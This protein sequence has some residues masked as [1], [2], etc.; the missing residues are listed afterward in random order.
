MSHNLTPSMRRILRALDQHGDMEAD[1]I[2]ERA[3]VAL[4]TLSGGG[5]LT[6]LLMLGMV[7]V[8]HWRRQDRSGPFI[9]TYSVTPGDSKPKPRPYSA[10]EKSRR[11]KQKVGYKSKSYMARKR[12]DTLLESQR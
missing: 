9:P 2:A 3:C 8:S 12:I 6:K 5:Y 4:S 1:E 7:R 11:W 10:A